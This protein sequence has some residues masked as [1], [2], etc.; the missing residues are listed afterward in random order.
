M[1]GPEFVF[2][3]T[4]SLYAEL[5]FLQFS[6][7]GISKT[8][9]FSDVLGHKAESLTSALSYQKFSLK[10]KI[11]ETDPDILSRMTLLETQLQAV[12]QQKIE[13]NP[14]EFDESDESVKVTFMNIRLLI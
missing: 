4:R 13:G 1:L 2:H 7:P 6:P 12:I 14:R 11:P 10:R 5:S 8:A 3:D 9:W